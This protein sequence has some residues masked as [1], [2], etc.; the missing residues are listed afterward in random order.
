MQAELWR[1]YYSIYY[2]AEDIAR[3]HNW[4]SMNGAKGLAGIW[5][6]IKITQTRRANDNDNMNIEGKHLQRFEL[7][8]TG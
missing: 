6:Y 4:Y 8:G 3:L 1:L 7:K 5:L 2:T